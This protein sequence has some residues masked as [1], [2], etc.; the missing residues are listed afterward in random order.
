MT[1]R[2]YERG[3]VATSVRALDSSLSLSVSA[4]MLRAAFGCTIAVWRARSNDVL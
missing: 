3:A 1:R 4:L 2:S